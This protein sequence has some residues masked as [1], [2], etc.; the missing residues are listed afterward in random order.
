[1][2]QGTKTVVQQHKVS[3]PALACSADNRSYSAFATISCLLVS[4]A[5]CHALSQLLI[6]CSSSVIDLFQRTATQVDSRRMTV[7]RAHAKGHAHSRSPSSV[8]SDG[9]MKSEQLTS[10]NPP[11]SYCAAR[12]ALDAQNAQLL[13]RV[14]CIGLRAA[15]QSRPF[16]VLSCNNKL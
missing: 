9:I 10:E 12:T 8:A 15:G 3:L 2:V 6:S 13:L 7:C 16:S 5:S 4:G 14:L 11:T 1:M